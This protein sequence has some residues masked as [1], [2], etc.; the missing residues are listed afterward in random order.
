[1]KR[2]PLSRFTVPARTPNGI[3]GVP[4]SSESMRP[5]RTFYC[6]GQMWSLRVVPVNA[7]LEA[8]LLKFVAGCADTSCDNFF[9]QALP[10]RYS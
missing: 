7:G 10:G 9:F 5:S 2:M 1:M 8:P 3:I 4:V 6:P